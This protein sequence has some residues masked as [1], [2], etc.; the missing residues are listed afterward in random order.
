MDAY[1]YGNPCPV[2]QGCRAYGVAEAKALVIS[3]GDADVCPCVR[4][5]IPYWYAALSRAACVQDGVGT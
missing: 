4:V 3:A 1:G 2:G 5:R